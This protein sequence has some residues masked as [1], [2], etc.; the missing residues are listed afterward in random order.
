MNSHSVNDLSDERLA[1][2]INDF[3]KDATEHEYVE[4]KENFSDPYRIGQIV[5]GFLNTLTLK[6]IPRGFLVWGIRDSD[7]A[8]VGTNFNPRTKKVGGR[9][10]DFWLKTTIRPNPHLEFRELNIDGARIVVL[11]ISANPIDIYK[12]KKSR[13]ENGS[14]FRDGTST[15]PLEKNKV[16]EQGLWKAIINKNFETFPAGYNF[17]EEQ[18]KSLLDYETFREMRGNGTPVEIDMAFKESINC[19]LVTYNHDGT[20]NITNFGALLY[21]RN[22]KQFPDLS[23][24]M[25]RIIT[26]AG[27]NKLETISEIRGEAGYV[28]EFNRLLGYI[29]EKVS[30][31]ERIGE[32]GIRRQKYLYPETTIRELFA[33]MLCHQ[34]FSVNTLQPMVEIYD[35]RIEFTNAGAPLVEIDRIIDAPP[36]T[37]NVSITN[38][39]FNVGIC[40]RRGSGWD[41]I[42]LDAK[43]YHFPAPVPSVVGD[44][45]NVTV[46]QHRELESLTS[47]ERIWTI[48]IYACLLWVEKKCLTNAL[49]R[50]LFDIPDENASTATALLNRAVASGCIKVFDIKAGNRNR[51]YVP[52]YASVP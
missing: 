52:H 45:T 18:V 1:N 26:Y 9:E 33:N 25:P 35:N 6:K 51:K 31:R 24:K 39:L 32:D 20:Y 11:I 38:E 47:E 10:F 43:N 16:A 15:I 21:A 19:G 23:C 4:F 12:C 29:M 3:C 8:V 22:I 36:M 7:H 5:C 46:K 13:N 42:A 34:D 17:S 49:T 28:V 40:E 27:N 14:Y 30:D 2:I 48:Y 50:E 41:K 44:T 37:R